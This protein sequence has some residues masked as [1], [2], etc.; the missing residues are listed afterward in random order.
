MEELV[1]RTAER[2]AVVNMAFMNEDEAVSRGMIEQFSG[3]TQCYFEHFSSNICE[4]YFLIMCLKY[5]EEGDLE[6]NS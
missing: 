5:V 6:E 2:L 1:T 4:G 3:C